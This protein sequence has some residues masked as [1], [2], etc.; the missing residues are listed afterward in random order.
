V[1]DPTPENVRV[2]VKQGR[3]RGLLVPTGILC[4]IA[5]AAAAGCGAGAKL[6]YGGITDQLDAQALALTKQTVAL[7]DESTARREALAK[8]SMQRDVLERRV[9]VLEVNTSNNAAV[10]A[11]IKRAIE[12][13]TDQLIDLNRRLMPPR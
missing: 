12:R 4:S 7:A 13:Q 1:S 5:A 11:E 8:E 2:L 3:V 9:L 10:L 6:V